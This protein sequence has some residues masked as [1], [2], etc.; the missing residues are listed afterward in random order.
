V[1][2]RKQPL[3]I[4]R[5]SDHNGQHPALCF[6]SARGLREHIGLARAM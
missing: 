4:G 2:F 6:Q 1:Y 5:V 3:G